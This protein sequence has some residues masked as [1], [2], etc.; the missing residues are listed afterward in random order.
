MWYSHGIS[1]MP[2]P[3]QVCRKE[4]RRVS[5][6][7]HAE[8]LKLLLECAGM[9]WRQLAGRDNIAQPRRRRRRRRVS[10][11][12]W[13]PSSRAELRRSSGRRIARPG[14]RRRVVRRPMTDCV[15]H[16]CRRVL[17][18]PGERYE[19]WNGGVRLL[20]GVERS[21]RRMGRC[22]NCTVY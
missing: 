16:V 5:A 15:Q 7:C 1:V 6:T 9:S 4:Q 3:V 12:V 11:P 17:L 18:R 21:H 13:R 10:K 19:S 8:L 20:Y 14:R 2:I 22:D